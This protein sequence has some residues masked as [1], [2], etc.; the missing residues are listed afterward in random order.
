MFLVR[1]CGWTQGVINIANADTMTVR[2]AQL[3]I[4][5]MFKKESCVLLSRK[6]YLPLLPEF[7]C[8]KKNAHGKW[9]VRGWG[10]LCWLF[11][12]FGGFVKIMNLGPLHIFSFASWHWSHVNKACRRDTVKKIWFPG[13]GVLS[14]ATQAAFPAPGSYQAHLAGNQQLPPGT[15][16]AVL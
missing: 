4:F 1:N 2:T 13:S 10:E 12:L 16:L 6:S 8:V 3:L 7:T 11:N 15:P 5:L 14:P 9:A